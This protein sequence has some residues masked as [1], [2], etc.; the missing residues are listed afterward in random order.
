MLAS[1]SSC[2]TRRQTSGPSMPGIIQ[3]RIA[4]VG[5][6]ATRRRSQ[7]LR[8]VAV[9]IGAVVPALQRAGQN[10]AGDAIVFGDHDVHVRPE[11][12]I[13]TDMP[14]QSPAK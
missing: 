3:S 5:S 12:V 8:A 4:S 7:R 6:V 10:L 2:R 13:R 1:G 9:T 11:S 14:I